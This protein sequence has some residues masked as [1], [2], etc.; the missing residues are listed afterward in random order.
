MLASGPTLHRKPY[1]LSDIKILVVCPSVRPS[2]RNGNGRGFSLKLFILGLQRAARYVRH[3]TVGACRRTS[4]QAR[5]QDH[6]ACW[7][8]TRHDFSLTCHSVQTA[9]QPPSGRG[10]SLGSFTG[11]GDFVL[12]LVRLESR[13]SELQESK[14]FSSCGS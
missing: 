7:T 9:R 10:I 6:S 5:T 13:G 4:K 1:R 14:Q 2:V 3:A 11:A 8:R 12:Q